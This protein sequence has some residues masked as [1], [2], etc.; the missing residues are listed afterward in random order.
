MTVAYAKTEGDLL[1]DEWRAA[2]LGRGVSATGWWLGVSYS[3][4]RVFKR[5]HT[6]ILVH[7]DGDAPANW[8]TPTY[9]QKGRKGLIDNAIAVM[10]LRM[11]K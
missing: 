5:K 8:D 1:R 6:Y 10:V 4:N 9:E 2:C 11:G 7:H 3:Q